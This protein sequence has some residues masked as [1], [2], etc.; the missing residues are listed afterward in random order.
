MRNSF[1]DK[2]IPTLLGLFVILLGIVA[3]TF[4]T[5]SAQLTQINASNSS[6]PKDVR[7]TNVTD[8]SFTVSYTTDSPVSGSINYGKDKNLGQSSLD[9]RDQKNGKI[10]N[11]LIHF[12]T[13][14]NLTPFTKYLFT[15]ISGQKTYTTNNNPF[16]ITT[17]SSLK[18][19]PNQNSRAKGQISL[20]DGTFPKETLIYI[21]SDNS[22]VFSSL[23]GENGNYSISLGQLRNSDLS[24]FY[25]FNNNSVIKIL[26]TDGTLSSSAIQYFSQIEN[27]PKIILS[28]NYDFR[29]SDIQTA[30]LSA[31]LE[32]FP[33][34]I[35]TSSASK[36][37]PKIIT[38]Q[39]EQGFSDQQP[40]FK[41][42]GSPGENVQIIIN[43][44]EQIKASV[45]T[46]AFG[47]WSFRPST[48]LSPGNH[49]IT[50][51]T[52]DAS[53][54]LRTITQSF[55]VYASGTQ[56]AQAIA[57]P[58]PTPTP[59]PTIIPSSAPISTLIPSPT[60]I[61]LTGSI[62]AT[63]TRIEKPLPATGN[64]FIITAGIAG[65][66]VSLIGGLLFLL[67]RGGI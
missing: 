39:K 1:W 41:G 54:I 5:N 18:N 48:L 61:I 57:S 21:T 45:P 24:S 8:N 65:I 25:E 60:E 67:S 64:P 14:K 42:T 19:N 9:D 10:N 37:A 46:D 12:I 27:I 31:N 34:F 20:L 32:N 66:F 13:V 33:S 38:P 11:Y 23:T 43:S 22:Q 28:K 16:E 30:S 40:L 47:N 17:A 59:T 63:P 50:I 51:I 52:K 7:I 35:S 36:K 4:L 44:A 2:R 6:Q 15:I 56:I 55:V 26:I 58:T 3:T 62:S 29:S 49:T 53:G